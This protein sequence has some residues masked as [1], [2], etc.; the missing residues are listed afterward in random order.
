[1]YILYAHMCLHVFIKKRN[2]TATT[3]TYF[4]R[5]SG[6]FRLRKIFMVTSMANKKYEIHVHVYIYIYIYYSR[7]CICEFVES[8]NTHTIAHMLIKIKTIVF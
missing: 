8:M 5:Q 6:I 2:T 3:L 4:A 1:M 7:I